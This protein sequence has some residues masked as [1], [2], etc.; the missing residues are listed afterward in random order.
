MVQRL[1]HSSHRITD[2]GF[3]ICAFQRWS[4]HYSGRVVEDQQ[5]EWLDVAQWAEWDKQGIAIN[6]DFGNLVRR[7]NNKEVKNDYSKQR[8]K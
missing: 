3:Y 5:G 8:N 1:R 2:T 4:D 6:H 7:K